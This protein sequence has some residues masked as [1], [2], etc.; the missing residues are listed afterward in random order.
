MKYMVVFALIVLFAVAAHASSTVEPGTTATSSGDNSATT[1]APSSETTESGAQN[2][3]V[4]A[5]TTLLLTIAA[6]FLQ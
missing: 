5:L 1:M 4:A 6:F 3:H 2:L